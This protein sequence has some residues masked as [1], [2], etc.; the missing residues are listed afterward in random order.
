L[1][2]QDAPISPDTPPRPSGIYGSS[3]AAAEHGLLA[4]RAE[5]GLDLVVAR[6]TGVFGPWQ[7]P[8]SAIGQAMDAV[9]AGRSHHIATGGDA[10]LEF[11]Y[12]KDTVRG[13]VQL[14]DPPSL[15]HAVYHVAAG[16][17]L[18]P[19]REVGEAFRAAD[20]GADVVFGPGAP[21]SL[22]RAPLDIGRIADEC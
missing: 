5:L 16:D 15:R 13:L 7:G 3:K 22:R 18:V 14:L 20:A 1:P 10:A 9:I 11:T 12:V 4:L 19:L 2:A 21:G 6:V 8:V 17:R